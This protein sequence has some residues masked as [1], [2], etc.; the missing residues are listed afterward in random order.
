MLRSPRLLVNKALE[1]NEA[2]KDY[3]LITLDAN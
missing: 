1:L 3:Q 2:F